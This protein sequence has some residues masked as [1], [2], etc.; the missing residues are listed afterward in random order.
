MPS[1]FEDLQERAWPYR[2]TGRLHIGTLCGGVPADEHQVVGWINAK[3]KDTRSPGEIAELVLRTMAERA[4]AGNPITQDEAITEVAGSLVGRNGFKRDPAGHLFIEGRQ[5]KSAIKE[6][7]SVSVA[8]GK[9]RKGGWG[10]T[11]KGL[12]SFVAEH[13]FVAEERLYL[14][15]DG[16]HVAEPDGT[17]QKMVHTFRGDAISYEDYAKEVDLDFTVMTDYQFSR[18]DWAMIWLTGQ[19]E[20][21]G[22]SR[23]QGFGR[24]E[25]T[26]WDQ[27]G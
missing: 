5:L 26:A 23:S 18:D 20:G 13:A 22:A 7:V 19:M 1:V 6:A 17:L 4:A 10:V 9:L 8:A 15:R 27:V 21:I 2:Y 11:K 14:M 12:Y 25:I 3:L 24:Y 16:G